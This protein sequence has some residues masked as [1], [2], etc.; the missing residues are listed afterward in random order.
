VFDWDPAKAA[1]NAKGHGLSQEMEME[2]EMKKSSASSARA[3]RTGTKKRR[4]GPRRKGI[5]YS[6]I[7]ALTPEQLATFR[8]IGR[9]T[10]GTAAR[11]LI[12]IRLDPSV[13][14]ALRT[15]A[16]GRQLGYQTLIND[17]LAAHVKQTRGGDA[18]APRARRRA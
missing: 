7:P 13:I 15:E 6:D 18:T 3:A 17:I 4:T 14:E 16:A 11:Q 2:T 12:A 9:P 8:R 1:T 10:I 5:D